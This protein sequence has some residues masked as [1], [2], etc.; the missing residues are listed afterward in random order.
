M[1]VI[2]LLGRSNDPHIESISRELNKIGEKYVLIDSIELRDTF[3][4]KFNNGEI[5]GRINIKGKSYLLDKIKSVWNYSA[6]RIVISKK[7][8]K[9]MNKFVHEEWIEGIASLWKVIDAK[10][11]NS[12]TA[13][14]NASNKLG[15]LRLASDVGLQTPKTLVTNDRK[16]L[17][18][19][20]EDCNCNI[21]AKTLHGSEGIPNNSMIYTA[22][23]LRKDLKYAGK[24]AYAPCL[25]Q[26]YI[27]KKIELRIN[28]IGN[29]LKV[30]EIQSQRSRR[31]I[32]DWR[33]DDKFN[34]TTYCKATI[35]RD[36]GYKLLQ[37]M[38]ALNLEILNLG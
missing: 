14:I 30:A 17:L 33:R 27:P 13:L 23:I 38:K 10:W 32:H 5:N 7:I 6:I 19:F 34:K 18:D 12:P 31:T 8:D 25:F 15:Q 36:V 28:I 20:F 16:G 21:I 35:P 2:A 37:L 4:I 29:T 22:K 11:V 26:E 9:K 1:D 24:L 3:D